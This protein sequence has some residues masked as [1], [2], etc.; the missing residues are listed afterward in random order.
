[1]YNSDSQL[2]G[3]IK[4]ILLTHCVSIFKVFLL[5]CTASVSQ[6]NA[7]ELLVYLYHKLL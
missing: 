5:F 7:Q 3:K 2:R 4:M 1:M 6:R